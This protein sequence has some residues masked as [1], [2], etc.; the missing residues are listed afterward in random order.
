MNVPLF[1]LKAQYAAIREEV[2]DAVDRV[3]ESQRFVL[4]AEGQALEAEIARYCQTNLR[5]AAP[6]ARTRYCLR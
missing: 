6:P 1:D 5:L 3:F 2:R 4:G